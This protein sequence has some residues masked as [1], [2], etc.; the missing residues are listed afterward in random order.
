[1]PEQPPRELDPFSGVP[2]DDLSIIDDIVAYQNRFLNISTGEYGAGSQAEYD[3][4]QY[5][6]V[7]EL[8]QDISSEIS[9]GFDTPNGM[10]IFERWADEPAEHKKAIEAFFSEGDNRQIFSELRDQ[11]KNESQVLDASR[12]NQAKAQ[13]EP[14][15]SAKPVPPPLPSVPKP[16]HV[17]ERVA[18]ARKKEQA[19]RDKPKTEVKSPGATK[20]EGKFDPQKALKDLKHNF[21][22]KVSEVKGMKLSDVINKMKPGGK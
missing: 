17:L 12:D 22:Q 10:A 15:P 2:V 9:V 14:A 7:H 19:E 18:E 1:M 4:E 5:G 8:L 3:P 16:K 13:P 20:P 11:L 6:R 21:L